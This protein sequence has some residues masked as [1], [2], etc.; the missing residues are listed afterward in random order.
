MVQ[1]IWYMRY[2]FFI[3]AEVWFGV[4]A[5]QIH[6]HERF[7]FISFEGVIFNFP[8]INGKM[9]IDRN[10][11][12]LKSFFISASRVV[13]PGGKVF[14][15][16]CQG[17]S[18]TPF[19]LKQRKEEDSW[20]VITMATYADLILKDARP[21]LACD[22]EDYTCSGFRGLEKRFHVENA[23]TFL[24]SKSPIDF[25]KLQSTMSQA[26][27]SMTEVHCGYVQKK[28]IDECSSN[29]PF[30]ET[31]IFKK[32][33]ETQR[34]S[35]NV[36]IAEETSFVCL[37]EKSQSHWWNSYDLLTLNDNCLQCILVCNSCSRGKFQEQI[38]KLIV[39]SM[40]SVQALCQNLFH[41]SCF[42][43]ET[44]TYSTAQIKK[45]ILFK[46]AID[47]AFAGACL[48]DSNGKQILSINASIFFRTRKNFMSP[49]LCFPPE[50]HIPVLSLHPPVYSHDVSMWI[51]GEFSEK[52]FACTLRNICGDLIADFNLVDSYVCPLSKRESLCYRLKYQS[53][54]YAF[55]PPKSIF[56]HSKIV[57]P[58]LERYL[59]VKVRWNKLNQS[60]LVI[61]SLSLIRV[62]LLMKSIMRIHCRFKVY[63]FFLLLYK[64]EDACKYQSKCEGV[65]LTAKIFFPHFHNY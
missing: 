59:D 33:I 32:Y 39:C 5:T 21:F 14:V 10:R 48:T 25:E 56:L 4:D 26:L 37:C 16:L 41:S 49:K 64:Q 53:L 54:L 45:V 17:Q 38:Q 43:D 30:P 62:G 18:G 47:E 9:K 3:G 13:S 50:L 27:P 19:D 12:L 15:S 8:H 42:K 52:K 31:V 24:F 20:K 44:L 7:E 34:I 46:S 55:S 40:P 28:I 63:W 51:P 65:H 11:S 36:Q 2:I 1:H 22:W 61:N 60:V 6:L 58:L 35:N 29:K 23:Y 57:G